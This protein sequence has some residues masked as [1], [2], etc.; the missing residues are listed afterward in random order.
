M[1]KAAL[2]NSDIGGGQI[3]G[4]SLRHVDSAAW[5]VGF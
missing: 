5:V 3:L 1:S 2:T 4:K